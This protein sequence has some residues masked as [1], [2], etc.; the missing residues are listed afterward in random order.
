MDWLG[1]DRS[2]ISKEEFERSGLELILYIFLSYLEQIL[3]VLLW[4]PRLAVR[5]RGRSAKTGKVPSCCTRNNFT[6]FYNSTTNVPNTFYP[7]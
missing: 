7:S 5:N 4:F 2:L 1:S 3:A 6:Q